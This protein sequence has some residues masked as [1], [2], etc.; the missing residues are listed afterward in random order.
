MLQTEGR[1]S[2]K[3]RYSIER[4][5]EKGGRVFGN[6]AGHENTELGYAK[7][8]ENCIGKKRQEVERSER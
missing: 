8:N 3:D 6:G 2:K 7:A 4:G 5:R 1:E